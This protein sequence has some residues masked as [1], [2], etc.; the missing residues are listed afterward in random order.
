MKRC[1]SNR[2]VSFGYSLITNKQTKTANEGIFCLTEWIYSECVSGLKNISPM[3]LWALFL[4]YRCWNHNYLVACTKPTWSSCACTYNDNKH[5]TVLLHIIVTECWMA[6]KLAFSYFSIVFVRHKKKRW[7][8]QTKKKTPR[9]L[10]FS[11]YS[12]QTKWSVD[13]FVL[14][15]SI[16]VLL[17]SAENRFAFLHRR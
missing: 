11:T 2:N 5:S 15:N 16:F 12:Q 8:K 4:F 17:I 13:I 1:C 14:Q 10:L 7:W 9:E 3:K 6:R